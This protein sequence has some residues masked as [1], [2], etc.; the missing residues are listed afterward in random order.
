MV[1]R[2]DSV[3]R[4]IDQSGAVVIP[5]RPRP[6]E[7]RPNLSMT[8]PMILPMS[9]SSWAVPN[10]GVVAMGQTAAE[11][12]SAPPGPSEH[13]IGEAMDI[14]DGSGPC[15]FQACFAD[16]PAGRWTAANA[17]RFHRS[18]PGRRRTVH[19][20][21]LRAIEITTRGI[22]LEDYLGVAPGQTRAGP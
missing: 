13:Q 2:G 19:R 9:R 11:S 21:H 4:F 16:Q 20:L 14:G 15:S 22:T 1:Y 6:M 10:S 7:C 5:A 17:H 8:S 18:L 12:I 3:L